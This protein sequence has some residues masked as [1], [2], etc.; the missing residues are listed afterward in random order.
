MK[1]RSIAGSKLRFLPEEIR[2]VL[3]DWIAMF[4]VA[5]LFV[6]GAVLGIIGFLG[7]FTSMP[8]IGV[9]LLIAGVALFTLA[10]AIVA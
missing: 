9:A 1:W 4:L 3:A 7:I 8:G 6:G 5:L 2:W 10:M